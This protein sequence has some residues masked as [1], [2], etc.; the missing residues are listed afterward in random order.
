MGT[1]N[2]ICIGLAMAGT[3]LAQSATSLEP[4]AVSHAAA[5]QVAKPV[6]AVP[7]AVI[8]SAA[9]DNA[10]TPARFVG[11]AEMESYMES[12]VTVFQ[13]M[14]REKDPFGQFQDPDAKPAVRVATTGVAR[15]AVVQ[16]TPLSE[17]VGR[18]EIT[19][20]M[21]G[22]RSFLIGTRKVVLGDVVP[23]VWRL[24]PIR[25]EV[26]E[27]SSSLIAFRDVESGETGTRTMKLLPVGMS[28]GNGRTEITAPGMVPDRP[29]AP[30]DL[31]SGETTP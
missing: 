30:I 12:M 16:A 29:D 8:P 4:R 26:T 7:A 10:S 3:V 18:L 15:R 13:A 2:H 25:V 27:V 14:S 21:P 28:V 23:L 9:S 22:E 20:I 24:K 5:P 1:L 11:P 17:I 19:T 31:D 6:K